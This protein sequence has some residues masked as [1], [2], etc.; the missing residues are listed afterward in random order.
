[1]TEDAT[2]PADNRTHETSIFGGSRQNTYRCAAL[3]RFP[4]GGN[5]ELVYSFASRRHHLVLLPH[6]EMLISCVR[7][8]TLDDHAARICSE[9]GLDGGQFE[10]VRRALD[11]FVGAGYLV[12]CTA[13]PAG[14]RVEGES[15]SRIAS[16]AI[17]TRD[18]HDQVCRALSSYGKNC[19][20]YGHD[21]DFVILDD[22]ANPDGRERLREIGRRFGA[23]SGFAVSYAGLEEKLVYADALTAEADVDP[24]IVR[25]GLFGDSRC[26]C[27]MGANRNALL[28]HTVGDLVFSADDDTVCSVAGPPEDCEKGIAVCGDDDPTEFWFYPDRETVVRA[29]VAADCDVLGAHGRFLGRRIPS[30][31]AEAGD[32]GIALDG[33]C[34]HLMRSLQSGTGRVLASFNGVLGD[35]GMY[36]GVGLPSCRREGTFM[37]LTRSPA[38]YRSAITSREVIRCAPQVSVSHGPPWMSTFYGL[39]NGDLLPPFMPVQRNED[40]VFGFSARWFDESYSVHL[41]WTLLHAPAPRGTYSPDHLAA[42]ARIRISDLVMAL[43]RSRDLPAG[44]ERAQKIESLGASLVEAGLLSPPDFEEFAKLQLWRSASRRAQ[45]L[46][47]LFQR[48]NG[49]PDFWANDVKEQVKR[50]QQGAASLEFVVPVD[51]EDGANPHDILAFCQSLVT[52]FGRL[53]AAWPTLVSA[54]KRLRARGLRVARQLR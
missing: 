31:V 1:M 37:R 45:M 9:R 52:R 50:L 12:S 24:D 15:P 7:L 41:P 30:I 44:M 25:F 17:P 40:T 51:L 42:L 8:A 13:A 53:L 47:A 34:N 22:S 26:S 4:L 20:K 16:I 21:N 36:S 27:T 10:A 23:A 14:P 5:A 39:D 6:V 28:L 32:G 38:E 43:M 29:G 49:Q 18:R 35:S 46:E 3:Q 48:R 19:A 11:R 54:A 33:T 2:V